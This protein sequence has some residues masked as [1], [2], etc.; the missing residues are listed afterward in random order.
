MKV[1]IRFFFFLLYVCRHVN[2][3]SYFSFER[4]MSFISLQKTEV[5]ISLETVCHSDVF[6]NYS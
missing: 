6:N 2:S 4:K 1:I 5:K 3:S